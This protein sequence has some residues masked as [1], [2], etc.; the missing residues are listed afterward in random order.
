MPRHPDSLSQ[1]LRS[2]VALEGMAKKTRIYGHFPGISGLVQEPKFDGWIQIEA[3]RAGN[4]AAPPEQ[5]WGELELFL[6][7]SRAAAQLAEFELQS[8]RWDKVTLAFVPPDD[9]KA[10]R[11]VSEM[12]LADVAVA[13]AAIEA[14]FCRVT[15]NYEKV[16]CIR[17][18]A[19]P[20]NLG[21]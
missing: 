2:N 4:A 19:S 7:P 8:G 20:G 6:R 3:V 9:A 18:L 17:R 5:T 10:P 12:K 16:G 14:T 21:G 13:G 1:V 15:L 11:M